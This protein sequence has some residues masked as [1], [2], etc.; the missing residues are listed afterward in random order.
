[1]HLQKCLTF[2]LH[3]RKLLFSYIISLKLYKQ[4]TKSLKV[5]PC[6][7]ASRRNIVTYGSDFKIIGT[8]I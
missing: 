5:I 4:N 8:L 3:I 1:M 6:F 7:F 2:G